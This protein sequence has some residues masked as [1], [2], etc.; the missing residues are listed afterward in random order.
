M[1][2]GIVHSDKGLAELLPSL[3]CRTCVQ[4]EVSRTQAAQLGH[5]GSPATAANSGGVPILVAPDTVITRSP[6]PQCSPEDMLLAVLSGGPRGVPLGYPWLG[7]VA[8][9]V[10]TAPN[11]LAAAPAVLPGS[12]QVS[13]VASW[14]AAAGWG[15]STGWGTSSRWGAGE[16]APAAEEDAMVCVMCW[17]KPRQTTLAPCGHRALCAPCTKLLLGQRAPPLC[18]ICRCGVQ[19]YIMREFNA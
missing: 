14:D 5:I 8:A 16:D 7:P 9:P 18:P 12:Q 10:G 4:G 13:D 15:T 2:E 3:Y 6:V 1:I 11:N 17:E 19:S